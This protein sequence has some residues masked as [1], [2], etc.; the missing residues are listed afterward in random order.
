MNKERGI[1]QM[2][3][4]NKGNGYLVYNIKSAGN[5]SYYYYNFANSEWVGLYNWGNLIYHIT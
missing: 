1:Y 3:F 2:D 4:N 5:N